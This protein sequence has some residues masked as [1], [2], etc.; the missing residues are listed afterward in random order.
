MNRSIRK[1]LLICAIV[2]SLS[3]YSQENKTK[4]LGT[5]SFDRVEFVAHVDANDSLQTVNG[6]K[7]MMVTFLE[8]NRFITKRKTS[9]GIKEVESGDYSITPD[10]KSILQNDE[11]ADIVMLNDEIFVIKIEGELIIHF[12]KEP[13]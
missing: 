13:N 12:K 1:V 3:C 11:Q 10:G 8:G 9:E 4:I 5:W 2:S 7:G 6:S